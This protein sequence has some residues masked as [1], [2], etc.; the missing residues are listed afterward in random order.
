MIS[1]IVTGAAGT[2]FTTT[3]RTALLD[4]RATY[5]SAQH[6]FT[7]RELAHLRFLRWLVHDSAWTRAMDRAVGEDTLVYPDHERCGS[8]EEMLGWTLGFIG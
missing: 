7:A 2:P 1:R 5:E 8:R 4:L 6:I 3:E